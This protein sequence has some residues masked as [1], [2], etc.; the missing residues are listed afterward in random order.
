MEKS[1]IISSIVMLGWVV[2]VGSSIGDDDATAYWT[3]YNVTENEW[4]LTKAGVYCS[5]F[6]EYANKP[7]EWRSKYYWA[8]FCGRVGDKPPNTCGQCLNVTNHQWGESASVTVRILDLCTRQSMDLDHPAFVKIDYNGW[9]IEFG[10]LQVKYEFVDCD[11]PTIRLY[12]A[13]F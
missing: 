2:L 1:V 6:P 13:S 12:S 8:A 4:D 9:G 3:L 7:Y 10:H 11:D 5:Q